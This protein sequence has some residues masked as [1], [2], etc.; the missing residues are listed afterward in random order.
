MAKIDDLT[1][2]RKQYLEIK[3]QYPDAILFFRLGDFYETFDQDAE[4][5]SRE[6]DIVLTSRN[7]A[8]GTRI[9]MAGIPHHAAENYLARLIERGY[10]VAICEQVGDQPIK[11]LFPRQ[12]VRVVTPGTVVEPGLLPGDA[13]NYLVCVVSRSSGDQVEDQAG[14]AYV[15]ITTGEFSVTELGGGDLAST[16]RAELIR[17]NPA[18][19]L[20]PDNLSLANGLPGH[21]TAWPAWRFEPGRCEQE[22]L[23]HFEVASLDGFGLRGMPLSIRAA[24]GIL[25]YL[26]ETQPAALKLLGGLSTYSLSEFMVLD[27][28]TRRN[29][30]LTETLRGG[31]AKGSLLD[32]LDH[33]VTPMGKRLVRQWVSKPLLDVQQ[34]CERQNEVEFFVD[35]GLLRAEVRAAL[36]PLADLERLTTRIIGGNA[37]PRDLVSLRDTLQRLPGLRELLPVEESPLSPVLKDFF[38]GT[39]ELDLLQ[40]ALAEDPPATLQNVGVIQPGFS[41]EL[42]GVVERSRHARDWIA[43][44]ESV[45]RQ[46]TGI[47][48]LKVGYNKVF[49]YYLEVTKSNTGMVPDEYI[50]KQTLVNAERYITPELK[51]YETLV[52]NAEE[53]IREIE[54]RLFREVCARLAGAS[55]HLLDTARSIAQL[56]VL[57]SL[58]E[59]AALNGYTRPEVVSQDILEIHDGR[60]PVVEQTLSSERFIPNDTIFEDGERIRIITGPNMSGK[61]TYLRQVALIVLMA[62]MGSFV[63]AAST[64]IGL[65]D[66][67][68][69]RI[70]AQDEIHAGQSTFMVEMVE[71]ANILHHATQRSLLVLDEIGRGTSTYDGVSIAWAVVEYIHNHPQLRAKTLFATHYHELTQLSELLPGVHN[72][73]VAVSE[74]GGQVVFLHKIV[75]GGADRSYGIHVGQLAGLPK[76]V[77]QRA[78]EILH[79]LEASSGKAVKLNPQ[80]P[81]QLALFPETNPLL[82][83]LKGI[84][85]NTLSPIEALNKLYEWQR[86]YL[87]GGD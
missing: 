35:N 74:S 73:N 85:M 15:D 37:L 11:G 70:G 55:N 65:V 57:A 13:N 53:R 10:H 63:P 82:D 38:L 9:P 61:S 33:T 58:A 4:I 43:S 16:L 7:V 21:L 46:R 81:R 54:V 2:I 83:E 3:R 41:A 31:S 25:Q 49:G 28:S 69:T 64:R 77:V 87:K 60:H 84:D 44:L 32:V 17:L 8:K 75:P 86:R 42:D 62:Q 76:P 6:L 59:A 72:H 27:A 80:A 71:T 51:E 23:R 79:Q 18:E 34:I 39:D 12:V 45:E 66:R 50:R 22:L 20:H 36:K 47:K 1:P 5:T 19:I 24:G 14:V 30:E 78:Q 48:S 52:L 68:F 29:L 67:I 40:S 26:A 56:D